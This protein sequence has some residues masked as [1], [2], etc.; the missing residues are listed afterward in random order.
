VDIRIVEDRTAT[1]II[2]RAVRLSDHEV[3]AEGYVL[4]NRRCWR[5]RLGQV[6]RDL[7]ARAEKLQ[8]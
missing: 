7:L 6:R 1:G 4:L 2:V 8:K 5:T 3:L